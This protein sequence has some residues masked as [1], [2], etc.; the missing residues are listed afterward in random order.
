MTARGITGELSKMGY[1][2][3]GPQALRV[4]GAIAVIQAEKARPVFIQEITMRLGCRSKNSISYSLVRLQAMGLIGQPTS[5]TARSAHGYFVTCR[6]E[7]L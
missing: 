4:L 1:L 6:L 3:A 5:R 2:V 7:L